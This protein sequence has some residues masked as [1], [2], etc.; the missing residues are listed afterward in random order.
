MI[1]DGS[2]QGPYRGTCECGVVWNDVA[3]LDGLTDVPSP[4]LPIAETIAHRY[5]DHATDVVEVVFTE[6]FCK[7]LRRY[8][9][10]R[11]LA[12]CSR[13]T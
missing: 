3:T 2:W 9:E 13:L 5:L 6:R 4:S 10:A 11:S 1:L 8:W 12:E 7:W